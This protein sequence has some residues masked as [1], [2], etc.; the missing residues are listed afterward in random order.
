MRNH[1]NTRILALA[2]LIIAGIAQAE[3]RPNILVIWG[4]DVGLGNI[5]AYGLGV[6]GYGTPNIDSLA[7]Q[8]MLFTDYYGGRSGIAGHSSYQTGQNEYR[9]GHTVGGVPG[10]AAGLQAEDPTIAVLLRDQGYMT[11]HFGKHQAG[12]RDVHL[13]TN[14]GFD[15]FIGSF[16]DYESGE[17]DGKKR[18][19]VRS[20]ANG[21]I[22]DTGPITKERAATLDAD[23]LAASI[24]FMRRAREEGRPFYVWWNAVRTQTDKNAVVRHDEQVGQ[25]LAELDEL[26]IADNTVVHYSAANGPRMDGTKELAVSPFFTSTDEQSEGGWRVPSIVRWPG[27]IDAG[28]VSN[29]IMHHLDWLPTLLAVAGVPDIRER[30]RKDGVRVRGRRY[31]VPLDG[32]NFLPYLTGEVAT[33]PRREIFYFAATGELA[34]LRYGDWKGVFAASTGEPTMLEAPLVTNLRLDPYGQA[35]AAQQAEQGGVLK[36]AVFVAPA[37]G[38]LGQFVATFEEFPPRQRSAGFSIE[39]VIEM[40]QSAHEAQ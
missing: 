39:E 12:D 16:Y 14:H 27:K 32:Y 36:E 11:G 18:G 2:L 17:R 19:V 23:T 5:S 26:G 13:P 3:E 6:T 33:G 30:L 8:G 22:L 35:V 28:R 31:Q 15:E 21:R 37:E 29:E 34:A 40:L 1:R 7:A 25:L 4:D 9:T 10:S 20:Y 24:D 38:Y